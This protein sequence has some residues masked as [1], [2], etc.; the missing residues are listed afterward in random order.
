MSERRGGDFF[1]NVEPLFGRSVRP[2][3]ENFR[4]TTGMRRLLIVGGAILIIL[5][6]VSPAVGL[7]IDRLWFASLGYSKIFDTRLSYQFWLGL[8]GFLLAFLVIAFNAILAL[9][10]LGPAQL[11]KIGVRRRVLDTGTGRLA[12]VAAAIVAL[13][14]SRV[15]LSGWET[16]ATAINAT[17][18]GQ[19]DPQFGMDVG[20]YVFQYP[21]L[22]FA[23]GWALGLVIVCLVAAGGIYLSRATGTPG[24]INLPPGAVGHLSLL[25]SALFLL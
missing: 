5:F 22:T 19:A 3:F 11:S 7:Y 15:A 8:G 18:F 20:F 2:N 4:V 12:L 13:I 10:L 23:W 9:R 17:N 16:V 6:V 21:L 24:T 25:A 14:F 1:D